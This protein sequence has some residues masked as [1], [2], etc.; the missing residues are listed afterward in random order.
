M[1]GRAIRR[2]HRERLKKNRRFHWG[3]DLRQEPKILAMAI[4]TPTP[5]SCAMCCNPRSKK[6][7]NHK[8]EPETMQ[9]RRHKQK[10]KLNDT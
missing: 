4:N 7:I 3:R 10:E 1:N 2:H 6:S 5:C 8:S 9:E